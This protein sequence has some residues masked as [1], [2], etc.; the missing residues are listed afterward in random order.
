[1][2]EDITYEI[3]MRRMLDRV[4]NT[5]DKRE[6]SMIYDALAP[7]AVELIQMYIEI[8]SILNESFADTASRDYLIRRAAERGIIPEK[9]TCAVLKGEF[10]T[11]VPIG[12]RF[13]LGELNY[14][15][16]EKISDGVFRM[17]CET[18]GRIGNS[19]TGTLVPIDY[20]TGLTSAELT[21]LLIP[22]EDEEDTEHL[23]QRYYN[24]LDSQSFGGNIQD[25][26]EKINGI[27]GVGGVKIYP[28]WNGGGTVKAVVIN[29]EYQVPSVE[30][31]A[32][33][34]G[35]V[36]PEQNHGEGLGYAPIGHVVTVD[37][38]TNTMVDIQTNITYQE[39]WTW[40]DVKPYAESEIDR[41]FSELARSWADTDSLI[42]RISQIETRLL[43]VSGV[44]DISGTKI[45]GLEQNLV[46]GT[47]S[48]P[49][50]GELIG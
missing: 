41:Y 25:Y 8:D 16:F 13:S 17:R 11:D 28:T 14:V 38:V 46:L 48:I 30:L 40:E 1:M 37:G 22:G 34:Q 43:N 24:S 49:K 32:E 45:G 33:V 2:Y 15:A 23:R 27:A 31:V 9:A 4:P 18:E 47:D 26:K 36:D 6:G 35:K 50:R 39:G 21:E 42:V 19:Q 44:V 12:A 10:N 5:V 7:A 3:I 29:S 20:V